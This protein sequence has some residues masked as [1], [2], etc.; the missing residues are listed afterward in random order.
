[1]RLSNYFLPI[2]KENPNDASVASHRLMLRAGM[3]RQLTSGIYNWLP[4]GVNILQKISNIV[5]DGLNKAGCVE[6]LMSCLQPDDLWVESGRFDAYG[7]ELL[8][9]KDRHD[10]NL[11]FSPTNEEVVTDIFR[12]NINSYKELPVTMYQMQWKFR[13]EIRPRFGVMRGREFLMKDAYSFDID[14]ESAIKSYDK[15]FETYFNIFKSLG[16]NTIAVRADSGQIGGDLSQEFHVI[17]DTGESTI[18]YDI[19]YDE[20][21]KNSSLDLATMRNIYAAADEMHDPDNCPVP[22]ERLVAKRGIEV[23][24]VFYLGDKY[25]KALNAYVTNQ[26]GEKIYA[27]MGCYGIGISRLIGAIIEANHDEKGII[28]PVE[29]APFIVSLVNLKVGDGSCDDICEKIYLQLNNAKVDVLYDDTT[30]SVGSKLATADLIGSPWQIIV[31]PKSAAN[32]MVEL[33]F[34]RTGEKEIVSIESALSKVCA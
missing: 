30:N 19:A 9:M 15:M 29:V 31:G 11:L 16:L 20:A 3:I 32:N 22:A 4:M 33:K 21:I 7:K 27:Q 23:G 12:K 14:K 18:Y 13:D 25:S 5:R 28:W 26:N 17:A 6:I 10:R 34:R 8:T 1:M 24:Q 2:L